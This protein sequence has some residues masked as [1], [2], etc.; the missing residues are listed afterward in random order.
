M[1]KGEY[2]PLGLSKRKIHMRN[3]G[4]LEWPDVHRKHLRSL[5]IIPISSHYPGNC[6][7][8]A[9]WDNIL[10]SLSQEISEAVWTTFPSSQQALACRDQNLFIFLFLFPL[11]LE[12]LLTLTMWMDWIELSKW[13]TLVKEESLELFELEKRTSSRKHYL[14][15]WEREN[16]GYRDG[17]ICPTKQG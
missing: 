10:F 7:C 12:I 1:N 17:Y 4:V 11:G 5:L 2:N 6:C 3:T 8:E 15:I 14:S 16:T 13:K 9:A